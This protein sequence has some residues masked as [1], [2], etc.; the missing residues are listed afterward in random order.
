M[1]EYTGPAT[2]NEAV[3]ISNDCGRIVPDIYATGDSYDP[4]HGQN[5]KFQT[6][7]AKHIHNDIYQRFCGDTDEHDSG[8]YGGLRYEDGRT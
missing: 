1:A 2:D 3:V 7:H 6:S 4:K 8:P 5:L